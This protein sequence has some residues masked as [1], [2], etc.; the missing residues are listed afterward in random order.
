MDYHSA[1]LKILT[2]L[3][4]AQLAPIE[5]IDASIL[6]ELQENWCM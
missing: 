2:S 6:K 1:H 4:L 5:S 3:Q